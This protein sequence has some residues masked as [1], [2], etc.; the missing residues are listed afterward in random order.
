M[1][2]EVGM[3]WEAGTVVGL[4][5]TRGGGGGEGGVAGAGADSSVFY[6]VEVSPDVAAAAGCTGLPVAVPGRI[7]VRAAVIR[8]QANRIRTRR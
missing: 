4:A 5:L 8:V 6:D 3:Y 1:D 7:D 2:V